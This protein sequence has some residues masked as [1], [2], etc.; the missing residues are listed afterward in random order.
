MA[1]T[2][3]DPHSESLLEQYRSLLPVFGRLAEEIP[4]RL[5]SFLADSGIVVAA[6]EHRIKTETSLE[7]KLR[8]KGGKYADIRDVTDILGLRIIT[9][10]VDDVDKVASVLERLFEI[11]WENSVDKRK[12]HEIDSFGYLSL[13]YICRIPESAYTDPE[14]PEINKIRFEVQMRTALQHVWA[15][16][17]HDTGYKSG[18]EVPPEYIRSLTRL[19]GILELADD[20]FSRI[21]RNL[22][23]YRRKVEVLVRDGSFDEVSLNGDTMRSYLSLD[24]FRSLNAKIAAINQA[25]IQ[26]L[27][28]MPYLEPMLE[29]GLKT[30]GDVENMRKTYSE[31]AYQLALHQISGTDLDIIASTL[32]LQNVCLVYAAETAGEKGVLRFLD[33]L[34]GPS[35]YNAESAARICSQLARIHDM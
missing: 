29:M 12:A 25:E 22:T 5:R 13:H 14:H 28:A 10:Y 24:P 30:L 15:N 11:D 26:Q 18:V 6:I 34:N 17:N 20:E 31:K 2:V 35:K 33:C 27:S 7:G 9:F 23:D 8:Q 1:K 16:M 4:Q 3:L 19:A 21:R 32:G